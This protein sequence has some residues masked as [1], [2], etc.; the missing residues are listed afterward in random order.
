MKYLISILILALSA[1]AIAPTENEMKQYAY[2]VEQSE[3]EG[4]VTYMDTT[5]ARFKQQPAEFSEI[6][7][8][9]H[10]KS[11]HT[12]TKVKNEQRSFHAGMGSAT[13]LWKTIT[14]K[15]N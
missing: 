8:S 10:C 15:C 9:N 6:L 7:I 13:N 14:Y 11:G 4:V 12:K 5:H 1:C 2:V 3:N